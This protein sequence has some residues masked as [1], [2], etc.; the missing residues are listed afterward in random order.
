MIDRQ[1]I[2]N[3]AKEFGIHTSNLQRDYVFGWLLYGIYSSSPLRQSLVLKGGNCFRKAYFPSTRFSRD[4]DFGTEGGV[5]ENLLC[6][7]FN[8]VCT[9]VQAQSGVTFE[10]SRNS[11][12]LQQEIDDRRKVYDV[13]LYFK[14]FYG[15]PDKF[16]ISVSLDITEFDKIYLPVQTRMLIHPYSDSDVC[17]AE[18]RC[19][20]LEEMLAAKLKCLLQRRE[21][22]DLYDLVFSIFINKDLNVNRQEIVSTFLRKTIFEPSPS[23]ARQLLLELPLNLLRAAWQRYIIC[24]LESV[25]DFDWTVQQFQVFIQEL[26]AVQGVGIP[27]RAQFA[28]FPSHIRN[29]IMEAG[30]N[31]RL[32][33]LTYDGV[34]RIV[35]PYSMVFKRRKDGFGQEY[36]YVYDTT[37]G[38]D[39]GPGIKSFVNTKIQHIEVLN[40]SFQPRHQV[41]LSKAG[42]YIGDSY[43][44]R[45]FGGRTSRVR[46]SRGFDSRLVYVFECMYCNKRF[47]RL[48][49]D[50]TLRQHKDN[51]GNQCF[52][53]R[54]YLVDQE[55]A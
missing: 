7:E 2:E 33:R 38:R 13:R 48:K 5:D 34:P 22:S 46:L 11:V 37:G 35:E 28:Y 31:L 41:N 26:F 40:D 52:G 53:R 49:N 55:F 23:V 36:L 30:Q 17:R 32:L 15:N 1:E 25:L 4:L 42:E 9:L 44:S 24:P 8:N 14:D 51:Y 43:F 16:T 19:L 47:R 29:P 12:T 27:Y 54:G 39:S 20:K 10:T 6:D 50:T 45:P 3:K 18:I 21:V